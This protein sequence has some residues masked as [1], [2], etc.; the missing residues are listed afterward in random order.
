MEV[1]LREGIP[2]LWRIVG[3]FKQVANRLNLPEP[4]SLRAGTQAARQTLVAKSA[5][6]KVL[7]LNRFNGKPTSWQ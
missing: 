1:P 7:T 2:C 4:P 6:P 5:L 3:V